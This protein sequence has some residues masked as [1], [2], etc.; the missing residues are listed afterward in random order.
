MKLIAIFSTKQLAPVNRHW[1]IDSSTTVG[2]FDTTFDALAAMRVISTDNR[3]EV[4]QAPSTVRIDAFATVASTESLNTP[5]DA[6]GEL[7]AQL[8]KLT[9]SSDTLSCVNPAV[10]GSAEGTM[11][12]R[13][14]VE[15]SGARAD[16]WAWHFI[17]H[18]CA[19][20]RC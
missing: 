8:R 5:L 6:S 14:T 7:P 16:V 18:A 10:K 19:P 17:F 11:I 3:T 9:L 4:T 15:L 12:C 1:V 13:L 2:M 20:A